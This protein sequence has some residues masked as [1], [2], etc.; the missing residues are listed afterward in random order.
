M[1]THTFSSDELKCYYNPCPL[2]QK[3]ALTYVTEGSDSPSTIDSELSYKVCQYK[4]AVVAVCKVAL[5]AAD[6]LP[7]HPACTVG[8]GRN[9]MRQ[10]H[11]SSAGS[12]KIV[13]FSIAMIGRVVC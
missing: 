2:L 11:E 12:T 1:Q 13:H 6:S 4:V 7:A 10:L 5:C 3:L 8:P 9:G